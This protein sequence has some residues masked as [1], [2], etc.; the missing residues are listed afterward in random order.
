MKNI[1]RN[2]RNFQTY[3]VWINYLFFSGAMPL[4]EYKPYVF[5]SPVQVERAALKA[6]AVR[7]ELKKSGGAR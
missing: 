6:A 3:L 5:I 4:P 2:N 7:F 1:L